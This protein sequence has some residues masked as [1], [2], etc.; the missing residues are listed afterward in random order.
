MGQSSKPGR[1]VCGYYT[2]AYFSF[3]NAHARADYVSIQ[4]ICIT[5]PQA[6]QKQTNNRI[7][8][9]YVSKP[10]GDQLRK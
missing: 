4:Y 2:S 8:R 1:Q 5:V 7:Y 10:C 3:Y 9:G 6:K